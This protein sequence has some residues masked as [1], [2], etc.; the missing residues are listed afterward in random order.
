[1]NT[2]SC[3]WVIPLTACICPASEIQETKVEWGLTRF[4]DVV[5]V[6]LANESLCIAKL[7]ESEIEIAFPKAVSLRSGD[8]IE[9]A[10][11]SSRVNAGERK[12]FYTFT[13][14]K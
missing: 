13:K 1:M 3:I 7:Q 12:Y 6:R 8:T 2:K 11:Q 9:I 5:V 14:K 4:A 10:I